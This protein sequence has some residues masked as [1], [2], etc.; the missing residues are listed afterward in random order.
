[1]RINA[2][3]LEIQFAIE[4]FP[5]RGE[6][7]ISRGSK[8]EALVV[9]TQI[10]A[11]G[12]VGRGECVPY[13]RYGESA[14]NV[15]ALLEEQKSKLQRIRD[16]QELLSVL[17]AGAARNS[18]DSALW[19]WLSKVN[20]QRAYTLLGLEAP[21]AV[22]TAFTISL[23]SVDEMF[24][25]TQAQAERPLLKV[26]LGT[27]DDHERIRAVRAAAPK[28]RIVVDANEGWS[29]S[30]LEAHLKTCAEQ[31]ILLVEQPLP[32]GNDSC[33]RQI[34][35]LVPI[36]ADESIHDGNELES[37]VGLYDAVNIKLDKTG[38]LTQA[39]KTFRK[40]RDLNFT[41]MLGCMVGTSLGMAPAMLLAEAADFVDLDGPLLL[42]AD[43]EGGL[44]YEGSLVQPPEAELWG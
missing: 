3:L 25:T 1:M 42:E 14:Q 37:L 32:E 19:D 5:I 9:T 13:A 20:K 8:K 29:E 44:R 16:P 28:A 18:V 2:S 6:F 39:F 17:P 36:C 33:L 26:K 38:G 15:C 12:A 43:R 30:I 10:S 22:T 31:K 21:K 27:K 24:K 11:E 35:H 7:K 40:A 41:I 4:S 23:G 34:P